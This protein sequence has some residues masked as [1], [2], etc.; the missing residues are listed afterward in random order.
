MQTYGTDVIKGVELGRETAVDT[1]KLLVHDGGQREGAER[2][3]ARIVDALRV[4]ALA[5]KR[6]G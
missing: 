5:C 6:C 3:H 1:E 2:L 4:L